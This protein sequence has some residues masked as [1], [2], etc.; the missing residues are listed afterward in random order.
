MATPLIS[1]TVAAKTKNPQSAQI[2][3]NILKTITG[4]KFLTLIY[5]HGRGLRLKVI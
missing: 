5:M 2:T 1:A 3:N 4:G